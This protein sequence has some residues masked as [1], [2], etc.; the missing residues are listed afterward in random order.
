MIAIKN[1][2][3]AR[4]AQESAANCSLSCGNNLDYL[5]LTSGERVLD[6]GCGA[7]Y[8]TMQ[9]AILVGNQGTAVG[10]DLTPEMLAQARQNASEKGLDNTYF[11]NSSIEH[12]P[13]DN[14][15][16][17]AIISNCVIN[18]APDKN[19]V[20]REIFRVLKSGGRFVVSDA[21]SKE[22][23]PEHIKNDPDQWAACFGGAITETNYLQ[24]IREAGFTSVNILSRREY[25]KNGY[26]FA[27]LT[28]QA[29]KL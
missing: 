23:L 5:Q 6:L 12:L 19:Q 16:F 28:I 27:S 8:E 25:L 9:A 3:K 20:Y 22:D 24:C 15:T 13:F 14:N 1:R 2:I 21:V 17:D 11:V 10:L 7:G 4:Y 18:H 29:I 26:D